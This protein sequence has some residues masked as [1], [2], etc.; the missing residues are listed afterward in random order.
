MAILAFQSER[1]PRSIW[2]MPRSKHWWEAVAL[3]EEFG[4]KKTYVYLK[5]RLLLYAVN[6]IAS[7]QE[8]TQI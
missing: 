4:G 7:L 3:S 2:C 6:Y 5:L 8:M 1:C